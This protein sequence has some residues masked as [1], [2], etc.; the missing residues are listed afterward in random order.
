[1]RSKDLNERSL[2]TMEEE[3]TVGAQSAA[4]VVMDVEDGIH[5][6]LGGGRKRAEARGS[7]KPQDSREMNVNE[8]DD[9]KD[10]SGQEGDTDNPNLTPKRNAITRG[11]HSAQKPTPHQARKLKAR[12][13][14]AKEFPSDGSDNEAEVSA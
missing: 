8:G 3:S 7:K 9:N 14:L 10:D 12:L 13:I 1:M 11:P 2:R 4:D 5:G 6:Q